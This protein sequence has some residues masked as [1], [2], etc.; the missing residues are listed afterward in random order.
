MKDKLLLKALKIRKFELFLLQLYSKGYLNGTVHTCIGQEIT[1]VIVSNYMK[2]GDVCFSNHRGHG[3]F[4][5]ISEDYESLLYEIMGKRDGCCGGFGGSQHTYIKDKFFSNG[6]QGGMTPIAVGYAYSLKEKLNKSIAII[7]IG[8]GTLGEGLL[9]ESLNIASIFKVPI[10]YILENNGIAQSTLFEEN[11]RGSVRDRILGFGIDYFNTDSR[12]FET[13]N[14]TINS[15]INNARD[16]NPT[17]LEIKSYRLKSHSKGDDNRSDSY[18]NEL[19]KLDLLTNE[20]VKFKINDDNFESYLD[21]LFDKAISSQDL[22]GFAIKQ[23]VISSKYK[24]NKILEFSNERVNEQIY[25]ALKEILKNK[26]SII[27]GE[28]IRNKTNI[29]NKDYGGA[30]KVTKNLSDFYNNSVLNMPI[31]ESAIVGFSTGH[32]MNGNISIS[33]IMFGD[34]MTLTFDQILQHASK[35]QLMYNDKDLKIPLTIRTPMGGKRGYGP[36]HS[37]SIEKHFLGIPNFNVYVLNHR[38]DI[39]DFYKKISIINFPKLIIENK[40]LY[41]ITPNKVKLPAYYE[42]FK[43][44]NDFPSIII[45]PKI[46]YKSSLTILCYGGTLIDVEDSLSD[47]FQ[48]LEILAQIIC[49]SCISPIDNIKPLFDSLEETSNL[50]IVEEG[51]NFASFSSEIAALILNHKIELNNFERISHNN[52]IPSSYIAETNLLVS[53]NIILN[54]IK[55]MKL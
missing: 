40:I 53:K 18:V 24:L 38:L 29:K 33:E 28:D 51:S 12:D 26:G 34:F 37:Q 35:F 32:A 15:A 30:F 17:F 41:N 21:S 27:V 3:H 11:F 46:G 55:G 8:D 9:Y 22:E 48:E 10:L 25:L 14:S 6:I 50:L 31:S 23:E 2:E 13:M 47:I 52:I 45:K 19:K 1:P 20:L 49:F 4:L 36:T 7:Y 44:E 42:I 43:T 54:T 16:C 5:S 39:I